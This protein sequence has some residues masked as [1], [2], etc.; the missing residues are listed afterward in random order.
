[1]KQLFRHA[2]GRLLHAERAE[3]GRRSFNFEDRG[4]P[5]S[6][7]SSGSGFAVT[8]QCSAALRSDIP[9]AW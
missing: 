1:V 6:L 9:R 7:E 5:V 8:D 2:S 4:E 3:D